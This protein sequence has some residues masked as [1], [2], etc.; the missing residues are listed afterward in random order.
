MRGIIIGLQSGIRNAARRAHN[1]PEGVNRQVRKF[2][3]EGLKTMSE[4]HNFRRV[5]FL[6]ARADET[7]VNQRVGRDDGEICL[8]RGFV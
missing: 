5:E 3:V 6:K 4:C 1:R 7:A 8:R 2:F